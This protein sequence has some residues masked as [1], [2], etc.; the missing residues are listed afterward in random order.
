MDNNTSDGILEKEMSLIKSMLEGVER[1]PNQENRPFESD[2]EIFSSGNSRLAVTTDDFCEKE[3]GF[4][5][6]DLELLGWNLV[7]ATISDLIAAGA[8]PAYFLHVLGLPE[9]NPEKFGKGLMNGI[10]HALKESGCHLLGGDVS[11]SSEWRYTGTAIGTLED[12]GIRRI[13]KSD[14]LLLYATGNYGD[15][16]LSAIDCT[17]KVK[18]ELRL[19]FMRRVRQYLGIAMDTSDGM[20]NT[21]ATLCILNPGARIT[22]ETV[23]IPIHPQVKSYCEKSEM[24]VQSFLLG[25]CGE[26]ELVVGVFPDQWAGFE[27]ACKP[28]EA[29]YIGILERSETPGLFWKCSRESEARAD[30]PVTVDPRFQSN[31]QHYIEN[32]IETGRKLFQ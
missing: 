29:S 1:S 8:E 13:S 30:I 16:N 23:S 9:S 15:G 10:N 2:A 14:K 11:C 28:G 20:R 7:I 26:Y 31:R 27:Q 22:V 4:N 17:F 5:S 32:I 6:C 21:L 19:E 3:D 18:F 25:S 24:P 12:E